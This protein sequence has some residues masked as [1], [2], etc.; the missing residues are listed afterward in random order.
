MQ[1][2]KGAMYAHIKA[3]KHNPFNIRSGNFLTRIQLF[4][5]GCARTASTREA[6]TAG[7][8]APTTSGKNLITDP[9]LQQNPQKQTI[10]L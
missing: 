4:G 6:D 7:T 10:N 8:N 2:R 1:K 3:I 9:N 5:R